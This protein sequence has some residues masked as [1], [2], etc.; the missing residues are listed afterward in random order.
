MPHGAIEEVFD[1]IF[2]VRSSWR[3]GVGVTFER[4]M[5]IVRQG[6]ELVVISSC[7]LTDAGEA[8]LAKLGKVTHA[9]RVASFHGAD[10]PYYADRFGATVWGQAGKTLAPDSHPFA[11]A[12]VFMFGGATAGL[13]EAA[14]LLP[15][16]GGVL[17]AGDSYQNWATYEH[18]S[19]LARKLM[20][21]MGFGPAS[22]GGPWVKR[23]GP[24][25]RAD[26][27]KLVE[28]PFKHLIPG[29]GTVLRETAR[30]QLPRAIEARFGS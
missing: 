11:S 27:T 7:R 18:C 26:F 5:T 23:M 29:H 25:V 12:T 30:M 16:D 9:V 15:T 17:V 10:D 14:V 6:S 8:E 19:W 4:T 20:P 2:V 28:L 21:R 24:G 22:I 1:N 13:V 3:A